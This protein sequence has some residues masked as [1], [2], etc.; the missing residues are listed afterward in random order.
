MKHNVALTVTAL[1]VALGGIGTSTAEA[2]VFKAKTIHQNYAHAKYVCKEGTGKPKRWHCE[3][4]KWIEKGLWGKI[5]LSIWPSI[6]YASSVFNVSASTMR[7]IV[8]REGGNIHPAKLRATI[9]DP[10]AYGI[11]GG[12]GLGWN[13]TGSYA[14]GPYQFMLSYKPACNN[15][16]AWGT[17][18]AYDGTAFAAAWQRGHRVPY[19]YKHPASNLGQSV[20]AAYMLSI[21][22]LCPH[23]GASMC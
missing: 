8:G 16:S 12:G 7:T 14:F 5:D 17:F 10:Y 21:G 2:H 6:N 9:C 22:G 1:A 13:N 15:P 18:G 4:S 11:A 3:A 23:W 20:V 19:I